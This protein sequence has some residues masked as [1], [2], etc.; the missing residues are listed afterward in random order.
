MFHET[1]SF[2]LEIDGEK[3]FLGTAKIQM[4]F[5]RNILRVKH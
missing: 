3:N 1:V 5:K 4:P 2:P